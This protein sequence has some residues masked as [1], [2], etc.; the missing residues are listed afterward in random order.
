M[1]VVF[2]TLAALLPAVSG[3]KIAR[4]QAAAASAIKRFLRGVTTLRAPGEILD[5]QLL[6]SSISGTA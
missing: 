1:T 5:I 4:E 6:L 3:I 2:A